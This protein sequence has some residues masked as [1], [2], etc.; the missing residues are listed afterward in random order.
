MRTIACYLEPC[1]ELSL[2]LNII[3][4]GVPCFISSVPAEEDEDFLYIEIKCRAEDTRF[5]EEMLAPFV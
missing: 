5:V 1:A 2:A 4:E 3:V